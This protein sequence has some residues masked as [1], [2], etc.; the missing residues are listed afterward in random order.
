VI[1]P[2]SNQGCF[3]LDLV[4]KIP[5]LRSIERP[6]PGLILGTSSGHGMSINIMLGNNSVTLERIEAIERYS[7]SKRMVGKL[8]NAFRAYVR[9]VLS[10]I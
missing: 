6:N 7:V 2:V 1:D 4:P 3:I 10:V 8:L 9:S 5:K